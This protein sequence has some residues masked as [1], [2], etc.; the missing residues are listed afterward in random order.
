MM[1][2]AAAAGAL[3]SAIDKAA[4]A[5]V[6]K[7]ASFFD[8]EFLPRIFTSFATAA[9]GAPNFGD[10]FEATLQRTVFAS[11]RAYRGKIARPSQMINQLA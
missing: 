3:I 7:I 4:A 10:L 1:V 11:S 8:T 5:A 2:S 6:D 9:P